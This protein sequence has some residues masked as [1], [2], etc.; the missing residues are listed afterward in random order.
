[1]A[2]KFN[3]NCHNKADNKLKQQQYNAVL[4]Q[5]FNKRTQIRV[6]IKKKSTTRG[7]QRNDRNTEMT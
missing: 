6:T 5:K 7:K 4:S 3:K 1:M 2:K